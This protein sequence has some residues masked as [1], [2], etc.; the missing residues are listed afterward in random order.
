M[1]FPGKLAEVLK[2]TVSKVLSKEASSSGHS[3]ITYLEFYAEANCGGS[4]TYS[5]GYKSNLCLPANDYVR[6]PFA[7]DDDFYYKFPFQSLRIS[8]LTG[9]SVYMF[10]QLTMAYVCSADRNEIQILA[11]DGTPPTTLTSTAQTCTT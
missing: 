5:T 7:D 10:L 2:P 11:M 8:N 3:G 6:P 4:I 1:V 9:G